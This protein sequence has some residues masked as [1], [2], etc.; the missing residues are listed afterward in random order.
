MSTV[1]FFGTMCFSALLA[2][3]LQAQFSSSASS[4]V[5]GEVRSHSDTTSGLLVEVYDS[6]NNSMVNRVPVTHGQFELNNLPAGSYAL[7]LVTAPGETPIM[8]AYYQI[9][10]GGPPLV[11]DLPER[12][13]NKPI[14]GVVA[15]RE[16]EHPIPKKALKEAYEAQQ[17]SD[18]NNLPKAIAKLVEA[19]RIDPAYRDAHLNLG[20]QYARV[21]RSAEARAEFQKALDIGPPAAPIYADLA[22]NSLE[23]GQREEAE[24][25]ARKALDLDPRN[26]AAQM[27]LK[28]HPTH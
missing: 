1:R 25:F 16:L 12:S 21:G 5:I 22:L 14:S 6:R 26:A 27:V 19:I 24:S 2:A 3:T 20:V 4:H 17:Y 7:R 8:E 9:G 11:L 18:A 13:V 28:N 15:L 10:A 23:S